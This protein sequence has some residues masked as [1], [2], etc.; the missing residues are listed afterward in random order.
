[1]TA[2]VDSG[3]SLLYGPTDAMDK[4]NDAIGGT[5]DDGLY[6]VSNHTSLQQ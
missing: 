3:T 4:I 6:I 2:I 1:M 5:Y